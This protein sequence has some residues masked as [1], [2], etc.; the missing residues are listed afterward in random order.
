MLKIFN[1]RGYEITDENEDYITAVKPDGNEVYAFKKVVEKFGVSELK[2]KM[3][4]INS[5]DIK[6]FI[7]VYSEPPTSSV[8]KTIEGLKVS[9]GSKVELFSEKDLLYDPTEHVLT[10]KHEL[11]KGD[12]SKIKKAELPVLL[13]TD[14]ICKY[15]GFEKGVIVQ[16][17]RKDGTVVLRTVR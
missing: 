1:K 6:H 11:Y 10:P 3:N 12:Q 8:M 2:L 7:I 13:S 16:I 9:K 17:T 5:S 14:V 4:V 15:Y